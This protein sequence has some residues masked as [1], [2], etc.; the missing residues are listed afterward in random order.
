MQAEECSWSACSV[1][2]GV[3]RALVRFRRWRDEVPYI[4]QFFLYAFFLIAELAV[5]NFLVWYAFLH[6]M[7]RSAM[8]SQQGDLCRGSQENEE[9][10]GFARQC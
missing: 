5:E 10:S 2:V 8:D 6:R 1:V 4:K 7:P 3:C 9:D